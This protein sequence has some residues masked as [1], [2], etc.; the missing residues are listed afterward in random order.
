MSNRRITSYNV[1]YTKL[2]RHDFSRR[3]VRE[4]VLTVDDLIYPVF[5]LEGENRREPV[6]SMPGVERL[7]LDLLLVEAGELVALGIPAI[8]LFPVVGQHAKSDT[9]EAAWDDQGL[10]PTVVRALKAAYPE[11]GVITDVALDPY[12]SHGQDGLLDDT[13]YRNNFV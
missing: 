3:L 10:V 8:A 9:A 13:G 5:V 12:T 4:Q 7:S 1:C 2:L 6:A 11:L